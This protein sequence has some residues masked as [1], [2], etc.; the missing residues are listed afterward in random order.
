MRVR[1]SLCVV[2][3]DASRLQCSVARIWTRSA[4][5]ASVRR[6]ASSPDDAGPAVVMGSFFARGADLP[7]A[8]YGP[9]NQRRRRA[10]R[11]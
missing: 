7:A 2:E 3:R 10:T 6:A 1:T 4:R 5:C 9:G 11:R 8:G